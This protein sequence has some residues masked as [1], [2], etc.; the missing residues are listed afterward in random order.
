M[1]SLRPVIMAFS[2][3]TI[4]I[5]FPAKSCVATTDAR[6]P[7]TNPVASTIMRSP[8]NLYAG[9]LG[10]LLHQAFYLEALS[11]GRFYLGDGLATESQG[12]HS[13]AMLQVARGQYLSRDQN[14]I[15]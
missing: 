1:L 9:A 8:Q 6:R 4:L 7:M 3:L 13:H 14:S 2:A 5:S 10:V 11:A 15:V 12:R